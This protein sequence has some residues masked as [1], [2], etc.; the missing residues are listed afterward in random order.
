MSFRN[1]LNAI[2]RRK[3]RKLSELSKDLSEAVQKELKKNL[4]ELWYNSYSP[5]SYD[6]SY[7]LVDCLTAEIEQNK[8]NDYTV[9]VYF[10]EESI[11]PHPSETGWGQHAGFSGEHFT[12]VA[13]GINSGFEGSVSNPRYGE[14]TAFLELTQAYAL[15]YARKKLR[16]M[17]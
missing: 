11:T 8:Q 15:D 5:L 4:Y 14:K 2:R 12:G 17:L 6:R 13:H 9:R 3:D 10:D 7:A 1:Q 16:E